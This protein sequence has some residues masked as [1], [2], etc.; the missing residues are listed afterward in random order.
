MIIICL[1]SWS[2]RVKS[3]DRSFLVVQWLRPHLPIPGECE[4]WFLA[5][6]LR[7][8][9][10]QPKSQ[11]MNRNSMITNS[12]KLLES[13]P[14]FRRMLP[15]AG[16]MKEWEKAWGEG[17][18]KLKLRSWDLWAMKDNYFWKTSSVKKKVIQGITASLYQKFS[19]LLQW[20]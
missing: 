7:S 15:W 5:Q 9:A 1:F 6:E 18:M 11:N 16:D 3:K 2:K 17:E 20:I 12:A 4:V 19:W 10:L 13:R 8:H 14:G